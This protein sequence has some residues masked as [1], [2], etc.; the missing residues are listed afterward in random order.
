MARSKPAPK[1]APTKTPARPARKNAPRTPQ[2]S[3]A[4]PADPSADCPPE[5][6]PIA[7]GLRSLA[8]PLDTLL[9]DPDNARRHDERNQRAIRSALA[10]YGQRKPLIVH[11]PSGIVLAGNGRLEQMRALGW[12]HAAVVRLDCPLPEARAYAI[13]DNRIPELSVWDQDALQ[14]LIASFGDY[15]PGNGFRD[16]MDDL[17][18]HAAALTARALEPADPPPR[19]RSSAAR[20]A[21]SDAADPDPAPA[22]PSTTKKTPANR[23]AAPTA[24]AG[25]APEPQR[26]VLVRCPDEQSQRTLLE[27]FDRRGHECRATFG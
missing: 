22:G 4:P 21:P 3:A 11:A 25:P 17:A 9:P 24:D 6:L 10:T 18:G 12:T 20:S 1:K 26:W 27:E 16:L 14:R 2:L 15:D 23:K 13:A 8:V 7:P 19:G 5:L